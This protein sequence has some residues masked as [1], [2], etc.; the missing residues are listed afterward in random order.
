MT[1]PDLSPD[2]NAI[3]RWLRANRPRDVARFVMPYLVLLLTVVTL[4]TLKIAL[5]NREQTHE[6]RANQIEACENSPIKHIQ[7]ETLKEGRLSINDPRISELFPNV[8]KEV[9]DRFVR[10]GDKEANDRIERLRNIDCVKRY[11]H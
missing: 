1:P 11:T 9:R 10:E 3:V 2:G 6:I 7:I 5:E 8:P 4:L